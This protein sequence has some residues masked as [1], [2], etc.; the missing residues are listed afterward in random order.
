L[1]G[2]VVTGAWYVAVL[3]FAAV[4]LLFLALEELLTEA[5]EVTETPLVTS[6]LFLGM[7][8]FLLLEMAVS[9]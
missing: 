1:L 6:T 2:S 8:A 9:H 4:A 5:H 7:L 3:A